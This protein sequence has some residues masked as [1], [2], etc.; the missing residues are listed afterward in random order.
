[1]KKEFREAITSDAVPAA[2]VIGAGIAGMQAALDIADK[3]FQVHLVERNPSIGGHMAQLDKT[4]P[5]LDCSACIITPKMVEVANHPNI[6]LH[7]CSEVTEAQGSAGNFK[8]KIKKKPRYVDLNRCTACGDCVEACVLK[9]GVPSEFDEGL[10]TRKAIYIPFPQAV[11][12]KAVVDPKSCFLLSK[13]KCKKAC[14]DVCEPGAI[15]FEQK[16]EIVETEAGSII[17]A[18]G[19]DLFDPMLK[20]EFGYRSYPNVLHGLELERLCSA[21]GPTRGDILI[22]GKEPK[23]I[24]FIHCVGSRDKTVGNEY[25]SRVCCMVS[26]KQA[27]LLREKLPEA[28]ITV[29]YMDMR[30]FGKGFEEFYE[31]V[32]RERISYRRANPSELYRRNGKVVV[33]GEDTLLGEPFE[34]EADLV[35][36]AAGLTARKEDDSLRSILGLKKSPDR[37]Y[38]EAPG[39]DPVTTDVDGIFLAG[40]CQGPKDI[41]DTVAQASGAASLACALLA[42]GRKINGVV[43]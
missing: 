39:L 40:C 25:C 41:P 3:G 30:A 19:F 4:F 8:V 20:P 5:T 11:P 13:G 42:K 18:T 27:H 16:E 7:T 26:A 34:I 32:Q 29:F 37:F 24:V 17:V 22:E 33:R 36:L 23:D 14:V 1:M 2:L 12:L 15:D 9:K 28:C 6:Q 21:S 43:E 35:V 10:A 38:A 31:R